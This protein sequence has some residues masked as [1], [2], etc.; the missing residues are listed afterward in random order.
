[1]AIDPASEQMERPFTGPDDRP[2][3]PSGP[4][5]FEPCAEGGAAPGSHASYE[6]CA[7]V[8]ESQGFLASPPRLVP[9]EEAGRG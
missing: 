9:G 3:A 8:L 7:A 5:R 4:L 2:V 1:M 6:R